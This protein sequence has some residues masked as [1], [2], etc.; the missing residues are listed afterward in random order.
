MSGIDAATLQPID[1]WAHTQQSIDLILTTPLGPR[2]TRGYVGSLTS[3]L[4]GE[5]LS[6]AT[7]ELFFHLACMAI[8]LWEPRFR[9]TTTDIARLEDAPDGDIDL[10]FAGDFMPRAHKGDFRVMATRDLLLARRTGVWAV[11]TRAI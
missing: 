2:V 9:V 4:L 8:A 5:N 1:P 7:I 11:A 6:P 3:R 10:I